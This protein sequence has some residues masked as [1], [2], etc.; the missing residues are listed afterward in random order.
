MKKSTK[1]TD[2]SKAW[3][4]CLSIERAENLGRAG[5][6]TEQT[7][8][9]I[10][11][12]IVER[13]TGTPLHDFKA[14]EWLT[15]WAAQKVRTKAEKTGERYQQV[16]RDFLDSLGGRARLSLSAI[17]PADLNRY[18][19]AMLDA[20]K[21]AR[22]ANLSIKVVSGGFNAALRQGYITTNPCTA[23]ESLPVNAE[24]KAPFTAIQVAKLVAS[25]EGD[26]KGAILLAYFTGA[27]LRDVANM[28]W[29][30]VDLERRTIGFKPGKTATRG[31]VV[32]VPLHPQLE[33]QLLS[34]PGVGRAS[35]FP[36]LAGKGTGG[37]HGLS[38]RFAAVME[39]AGIEPRITKGAK[40]RAVSSLSFHSLRHSFN[41][42]MANAGVAQEVRQKLTG[43]ASAEM[44]KLY[45]H[46]ELE[47]LRAAIEAIP[48]L[49]S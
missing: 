39:R 12:E 13:T 14:G 42:A 25:A 29:Q 2:R 8:K 44:N 48:M 4:V 6:L 17:S 47:P 33:R 46:H 16:I 11:A 34:A 43:H 20:G 38:G 36:T 9:K 7:A 40:G 1:Q 21:A 31:K 5:T 24:E 23:L 26:W 49:A 30:A 3:E 41:S 27:R 18:R 22:T 35:L 15:Q 10:L 45:T 37:K 32:M 19:E 28:R